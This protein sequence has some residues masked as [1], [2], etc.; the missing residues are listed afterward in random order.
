MKNFPQ[1]YFENVCTEMVDLRRGNKLS[2]ACHNNRLW[3]NEVHSLY[4]S[5][6]CTQEHL[7]G[8]ILQSYSIL[9][10]TIGSVMPLT[11]LQ[12]CVLFHGR[13]YKTPRPRQSRR[14][15]PQGQVSVTE[16]E[17][18]SLGSRVGSAVFHTSNWERYRQQNNLVF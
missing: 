9:K 7:A 12:I 1:R 10:L 5:L 3:E 13:G 17:E 4:P 11:G 2:C 15:A 8:F 16:E 6:A 18:E 14:G